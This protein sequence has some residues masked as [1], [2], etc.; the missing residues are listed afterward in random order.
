MDPDSEPP[1]IA[2]KPLS[3][4]T[5]RPTVRQGFFKVYFPTTTMRDHYNPSLQGPVEV[6]RHHA[7]I[8]EPWARWSEDT[9]LHLVVP[10]SNPFR[11]RTRRVLTNNFIREMHRTPNV[12][13]Y[14][15]E[16]AYGERPF[17]VTS[18]AEH[19]DDIQLR[20]SDEMFHKEN[21][22]NVG[23]SRVDPQAKYM[24]YCDA[25][26]TFTRHDWALEAIHL[27]QHHQF[28]QLFATY[29]DVAPDYVPNLS[30]NHGPVSMQ[31]TYARNFLLGLRNKSPYR[32][33]AGVQ[34]GSP[35]GAWAFR[36]S[37]LDLV[38]GLLDVCILGSGDWHMAIGLTQ[39]KDSHPENK[40]GSPGY[41]AAIRQ[42]QERA[43]K[44]E[45]NIGCV[46]QFAVHHWHGSK[47]LRGYSSRP[48]IL[49]RHKYDPHTDLKRDWQGVYQLTGNKPEFRDDIRRYFLSRDEDNPA[50]LSRDRIMI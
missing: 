18:R 38:G 34:F 35:G 42:W 30:Q 6:S 2:L 20:T 10:Y 29:C 4:V 27:L 11:S 40:L 43:K 33:A 31:S 21:L 48:S 41:L 44:I 28:V 8:H 25:D 46:N 13:L 22:I 3:A 12:R 49:A 23:L 16:L 7:D 9:T 14:V 24:A 1:P 45:K 5:K 32:G 17:E 50:L 37:A 19:R 26:F 39:E 15:V 47:S 36:R